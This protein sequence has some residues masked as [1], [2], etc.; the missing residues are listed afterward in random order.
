MGMATISRMT[1]TVVS[2]M[3]KMLNKCKTQETLIVF[4]VSRIIFVADYEGKDF[5]NS[6][7]YVFEPRVQKC[8]NG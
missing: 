8:D 4:K 7:R 5:R 6:D 2:L 3:K 1:N